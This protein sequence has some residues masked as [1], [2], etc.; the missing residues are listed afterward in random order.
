MADG[1]Y[2]AMSGVSAQSEALDLAANN[3]ANASTAG[4]KAERASFAEILA[5][6]GARGG[7]L[8]FVGLA[9]SSVDR[10]QGQ[11]LDT[12]N[13]LDVAID[14]EG[15]FA[16]STPA[17]VR[18][19]RAGDFRLDGSGTLVTPQGHPVRGVDGKPIQI[20][21]WAADV[22]I[23]NDGTV[24]SVADLQVFG[25]LAVVQLDPASA[26]REGSRLFAG[27]E[28][29]APAGRPPEL[30]S[31]ALEQANYNAVRGMVDLVRISRV[32]EAQHRM[33]EAYRDVNQRAARDLGR[34]R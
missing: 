25:Q 29:P 20:P 31:G 12:G 7:E 33:I 11:I 34:A 23:G 21:A 13:P 26:V 32:H 14:G 5:R 1:I 4:F 10:T 8:A 9:G 27:R 16:V 30:I 18:Y 28:V 19:T 2:L 3:L 24:Q 6:N 17:G 15:Y 22:A